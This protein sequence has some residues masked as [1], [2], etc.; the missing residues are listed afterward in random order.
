MNLPAPLFNQNRNKMIDNHKNIKFS[1]VDGKLIEQSDE[2]NKNVFFGF[3]LWNDLIDQ[4]RQFL[5][6]QLTVFFW[7]FPSVKEVK[8]FP[9]NDLEGIFKKTLEKHCSPLEETLLK[10]ILIKIN[11]INK[12]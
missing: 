2:K 11:K 8:S 4:E 3:H 7:R 10:L 1:T 5:V 9:L 6:N 12:Q